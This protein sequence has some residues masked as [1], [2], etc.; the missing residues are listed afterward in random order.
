MEIRPANLQDA[1]ALTALVIAFRNHLERSLPSNTQFADSVSRLLASGD[2]EFCIAF[3]GDVALGYVVQRYRYSMWAAG[4]EATIEDLFVDPAA[5][6]GGIG[7]KLIEYALQRARARSCTSVCLDTNENNLGSTRIY[8]Q[9]GFNSMS[10]R[11]NGRQIFYRLNL[12]HT[13]A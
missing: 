12:T 5:R 8:M 6:K 11:W 4:V 1:P 3:E 13:P 2:A 7:T 9:L 10:K